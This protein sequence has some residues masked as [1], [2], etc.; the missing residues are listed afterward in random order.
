ML[1]WLNCLLVTESRSDMT[2]MTQP[3][4]KPDSL[5]SVTGI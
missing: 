4:L 5:F 3:R 1:G 2:V